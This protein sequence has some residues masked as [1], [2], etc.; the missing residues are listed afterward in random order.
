MSYSAD[1]LLLAAKVY[2]M[3]TERQRK[4]AESDAIAAGISDA[5]IAEWVSKWADK[6]PR[7]NFV[8]EVLADLADIVDLIDGRSK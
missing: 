5:E 3:S 7:E 1:K 6:N 2:E 4:A 8:H